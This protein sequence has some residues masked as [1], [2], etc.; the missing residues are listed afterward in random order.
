[1][2]PRACCSLL[3]C[4]SCQGP[5]QQ[6][7]KSTCL[8]IPN[9]GLTVIPC[10]ISLLSALFFCLYPYLLLACTLSLHLSMPCPTSHLRRPAKRHSFLQGPYHRIVAGVVFNCSA[11]SGKPASCPPAPPAAISTAPTAGT[12]PAGDLLAFN[13]LSFLFQLECGRGTL[14]E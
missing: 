11:G 9:L 8:L 4:L 2:S 13:L 10:L 3:V 7:C 6:G 5:L 14:A 12:I 1:M